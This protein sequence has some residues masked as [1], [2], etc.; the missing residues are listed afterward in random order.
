MDIH[1]KINKEHYKLPSTF[2][3]ALL[4]RIFSAKINVASGLKEEVSKFFINIIKSNNSLSSGL[5]PVESS[6]ISGILG[7]LIDKSMSTDDSQE[8]IKSFLIKARSIGDFVTIVSGDEYEWPASVMAYLELYRLSATSD[9]VCTSGEKK[10]FSERHFHLLDELLSLIESMENESLLMDNIFDAS[11][12]GCLRLAYCED[13]IKNAS[14]HGV[15]GDVELNFD[16]GIQ[17]HA[18]YNQERILEILMQN[19]EMNY[20]EAIEWFDFNIEGSYLGAG[21]PYFVD[22]ISLSSAKKEA[23]IKMNIQQ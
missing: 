2:N 7:F 19:E 4:G 8:Y 3:D 6:T 18:V 21:M 23:Q 13:E 10:A 16:E 12:S 14:N 15:V 17:C 22:A 1:K 9:L 20:E 11:E 5:S